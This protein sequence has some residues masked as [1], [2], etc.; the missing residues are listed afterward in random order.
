MFN[1]GIHG[2]KTGRGQV[3]IGTL[4]VFIAMIFV[5]TLAAGV[6]I[7]AVGQLQS[8]SSTTGEESIEQVN[9]R[10]EVFH[11]IG[12]VTQ[13]TGEGEPITDTN[14][15][16]REE[17]G[18]VRNGKY[19]NT[20]EVDANV[21]TA[22]GRNVIVDNGN[23]VTED[24]F[25]VQREDGQNVEVSGTDDGNIVTPEGSVEYSVERDAEN[26]TI[27][28]YSDA[29]SGQSNVE[30]ENGIDVIPEPAFNEASSVHQQIKLVVGPGSGSGA[31]DLNKTSIHYIGPGGSVHFLNESAAHDASQPTFKT[32]L[33]KGNEPASTLTDRSHRT[34]I[35]IDLGD[36]EEV[37]SL[38][39]NDDIKL[40]I[41]T[42]SGGSTN[43]A[44]SVSSPI[45]GEGL[46]ELN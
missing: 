44:F 27:I 20:T 32:K 33:I 42:R 34:E 43:V 31:I 8:Q 18:S 28:T 6:L 22:D 10:I 12:D 15:V 16:V 29:G 41:T 24:G 7:S 5:A 17:D 45:R 2:G 26:N 9:D 36:T 3:G 39:R 40:T 38:T 14:V 37:E 21:T 1:T 4:I 19:L 30:T 25:N 13:V 11:A 35:I 23:V 46:F